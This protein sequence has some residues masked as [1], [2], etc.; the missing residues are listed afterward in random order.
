[1][2]KLEDY[3]YYEEKNPDLKIYCG[4]CLE[5]MP[6]LPKVDLVMTSPPYD[7]LRDYD[8]QKT[9]INDVIGW[10]SKSIVLGGCIV[11]IVDDKT[12]NGSETMSSFS[13][14]ISFRGNG[15][16]LHDTMIY[17]KDSCPFPEFNRYYPS[18]EYMFIL[19]NGKPKTFNALRDKKNV[20]FGKSVTSSTQRQ[21]DGSTTAVSAKKTNPNKV[22]Y[23]MGVRTN[24]WKYSPGYMKSTNWKPAF[25]HP[26][27]FPEALAKD[28][29]YS[30]S[31]KNDV[32]LDPFLG[33]GTTLFACK[34]LNRNGIGIEISE[35]YCEIA[36][37]RLRA[38][39]KSLF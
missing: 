4:D 9:E 12:E 20:R 33:S 5:V 35:K 16:N 21:K 14:A 32:V 37:K 22:V 6:L 11:W 30:W 39:T 29:I 38:T 8:G 17:A 3:L 27:I 23:E 13:H 10:V 15:L 36:K 26:A 25:E 28:H 24:I 7:D 1:M 19:S 18:F 31:N 34:E 2:K